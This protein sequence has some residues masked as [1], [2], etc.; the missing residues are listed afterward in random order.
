MEQNAKKNFLLEL[1][2][3]LSVIGIVFVALR[4]LVGYMLPFL[5]ALAVAMAVQHPAKKISGTLK[6]KVGKVAAILSAFLFVAAAMAALIAFYWLAMA[7]KGFAEDIPKLLKSATEAL[8][9]LEG[10]FLSGIRENSPELYEYLNKALS[11]G[12]QGVVVR[13]TNALSVKAADFAKGLPAFLF[14]WLAAL[15][16]SCYIAKDYVGL[17]KFFKALCSKRIYDNIIKIKG[18][19]TGSIF[20]ILRGYLLL[21]LMTFVLLLLGFLFLGIKHAMILSIIIALVDILPVF[22]TGTVLLPWGIYELA[23]KGGIRGIGIIALYVVITLLRNFAEPKIIG[24]Q[25]GI[26]PLFMLISM[27]VGLR[28]FGVLGL[29]ALPISLIT[30]IKFYKTDS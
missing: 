9:V 6:I 19:V 14:S 1:L 2:F 22:G 24:G 23:V 25:I 12:V 18:I 28:L 26:N 8:A 15:V 11:E 21:M 27:F 13:L 3:A 20:K 30:V 7:I 17:K 5:V 10:Y 29:F 16:A 4:L